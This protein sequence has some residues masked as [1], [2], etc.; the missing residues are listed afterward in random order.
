MADDD[1]AGT[2]DPRRRSARNVAGP[3][4]APPEPA[5][6]SRHA[7]DLEAFAR[8]SRLDAGGFGWLDAAG[9]VDP[10]QPI[11]AW[12]T[13]RMTYVFALAHLRGVAD[14][15]PLV[16]HGLAALTGP[17]RDT[18]HDGWY[19]SVGRDGAPH[20]D[21]KSAYPHAFVVLAAAT[22]TLAGR[23]GADAL[24]DDVL[25]IV[26]ERLWDEAAGRTIESYARDW[27]GRESYRGA[28]SSM[29]MVEAFLAAGDAT[30]DPAWYER[31]LRICAH[32]IHD[33][34]A[35]RNWRLPEHFTVDWAPIPDYN[36]AHPSDPFRPYGVTVGHQ[37]EWARLLIH[38]ETALPDPP[39]WL[40]GDA[41][42][43][44]GA[45]TTRGWA[46]DGAPGF[47]YTLDWDDRPVVRERMHWV[48][49][50]AISAAAVLAR[51]TA[52]PSYEQWLSTFWEYARTYL[53]DESWQHELDVNNRPSATVWSGKPD[54]YH[55]YQAT[56]FSGT[57][58][59]PTLARAL[60]N[61]A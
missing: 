53:I 15:A 34:A 14:V 35:S 3:P 21:R 61:A 55:A 50:E 58:L 40:L 60:R 19:G 39:R 5:W 18:V 22:A 44:F 27:S 32:L 2:A 56:L 13:C 33:V 31:A 8:L 30:N 23:P 10:D 46:V 7:A 52:D 45:A 42:S 51:R 25:R 57:G 17:L 12:I 1:I 54:V 24:L 49:A 36:M 43:L 20:D 28:N 6:L 4:V 11:H 59:A 26:L 47:V 48:V 37:L 16:D 41:I 29:H 38:V 9:M